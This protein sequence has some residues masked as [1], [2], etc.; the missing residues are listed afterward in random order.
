[1]WLPQNPTM[2]RHVHLCPSFVFVWFSQLK[3]KG[4]LD[5]ARSSL[6]FAR[7]KGFALVRPSSL[8]THAR[9]S[10]F[11]FSPA[12]SVWRLGDGQM[13]PVWAVLLLVFLECQTYTVVYIYMIIYYICTGCGVDTCILYIYIYTIA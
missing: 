9:K 3:S 12:E 13:A 8:A 10:E 11:R 1:M 7:G 6:T 5:G 2:T 4:R